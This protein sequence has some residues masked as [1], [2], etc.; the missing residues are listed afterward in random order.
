MTRW[1][2]LAGIVVAATGVLPGA[3]AGTSGL[4]DWPYVG[5]DQAHS[6]YSPADQITPANVDRLEIAWIWEPNEMP[7]PEYNARP[8]GFEGNP[9]MIDNGRTCMPSTRLPVTRSGAA[10]CPIEPPPTR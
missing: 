8:G 5:A 9:I 1:C 3:Q 2:G 4:V 7:M 10:R 6:K